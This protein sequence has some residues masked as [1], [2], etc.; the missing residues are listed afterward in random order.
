M[1]R[2][3]IFVFSIVL[4]TSCRKSPKEVNACSFV[5]DSD[6]YFSIVDNSDSPD[7]AFNLFC[8][9]VDVFGVM[10][11]ATENVTDENLLHAANLMAQYLDNDEDGIIDDQLVLDS[12]L[13][14]GSCMAIFGK[15]K[16]SAQRRFFRHD[17]SRK[18]QD[19]YNT[20]TR[21]G[22]RGG[23]DFDASLEEILHLL[24]ATGWSKAYPEVFGE[25]KGSRLCNA[26]DI[27]RGGQYEAIP[28]HYPSEAW[29]HY[30]DQTCEYRCMA[31]EYFY[32][33]LT[34]HLGAQDQRCDAINQEWEICT[35]TDL[36]ST[37]KAIYELLTDSS[38][39]LPKVLPDG[40]YMR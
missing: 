30:N 6:N 21:P 11:Y 7:R 32:W 36:Q 39:A 8:K 23:N 1:N 26:M 2:I 15:D 35:P 5:N 18:A 16:S 14:H 20:E 12:M 13:S 27:A 34:T 22:G 33:A 17:A 19:L 24:T 9:K 40:G 28:K 31:T 3:L 10:L 38:F 37:D 29:Y 25:E 4:I